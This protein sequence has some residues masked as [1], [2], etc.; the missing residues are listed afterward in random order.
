MWFPS[1]VDWWLGIILALLPFAS[2]GVLVASDP[3]EVMAGAVSGLVIAALYGL[4][5]FPMRYGIA[6]DELI[7]RFG[8]VRQRIPLDTIQ[9]VVPT[10]NP[11]SSPALSLDRLAVRT[12]T[13][14]LSAT[15][16]SPADRDAFLSTLAMH[17]GLRRDGDRLVRVADTRGTGS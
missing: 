12:G 17:S 9:E 14:L 15:M 7:V 16:I 3:A 6:R 11:L 10:H 8:V 4:L 2:L 1:K 13:G 5:V